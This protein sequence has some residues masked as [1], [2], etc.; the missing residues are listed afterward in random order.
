LSLDFKGVGIGNGLT[1]PFAQYPAYA[2]FS[3]END[4]ISEQWNT[5]LHY[6]FM[7]CDALIYMG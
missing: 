2:T 1:D 7:V 4:L 6:G 3:Y 5:V